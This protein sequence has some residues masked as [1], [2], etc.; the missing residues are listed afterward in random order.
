MHKSRISAYIFFAGLTK[1]MVAFGK[2]M[3]IFALI[4]YASENQPAH[5]TLYSIY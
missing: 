1:T 3:A 4:V 5:I 2:A